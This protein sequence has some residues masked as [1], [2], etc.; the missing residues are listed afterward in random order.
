MPYWYPILVP[1]PVYHLWWPLVAA[2]PHSLPGKC[3]AKG[4]NVVV[5]WWKKQ[6]VLA[7]RKCETARGEKT[8]LE[9]EEKRRE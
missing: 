2:N 3:D 6:E 7:D 5:I 1:I 9:G 4:V 8:T